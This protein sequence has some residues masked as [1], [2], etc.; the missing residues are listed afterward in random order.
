MKCIADHPV[1]LKRLKLFTHFSTLKH[2]NHQI[3]IAALSCM[4]STYA[5]SEK[6]QFFRDRTHPFDTD[7]R[8]WINFHEIQSLT[9]RHFDCNLPCWEGHLEAFCYPTDIDFH[10]NFTLYH[11]FTVFVTAWLLAVNISVVQ[12]PLP[13]T[14]L[15]FIFRKVCLSHPLICQDFHDYSR[16]KNRGEKV[17]NNKKSSAADDRQLAAN[18]AQPISMGFSKSF[19]YILWVKEQIFP[20]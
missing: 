6:N 9:R 2:P 7:I 11:N 14:K 20:I 8:W 13:L 3:K 19:S 18:K 10:C 5:N 1:S 4:H 17:K 12:M 15:D 16:N